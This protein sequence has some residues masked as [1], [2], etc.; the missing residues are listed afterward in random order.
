M[1]GGINLSDKQ[2][3]RIRGLKNSVPYKEL[4]PLLYKDNDIKIKNE[5]W[6]KNIGDAN[7]I[8]KKDVYT[9]MSTENKRNS[10]MM[11]ITK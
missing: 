5:K 1:Y 8:V 4:L 6:Y 7:I 9:L 10:F 11:I 3:V 2:Y